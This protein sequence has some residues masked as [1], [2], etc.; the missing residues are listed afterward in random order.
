MAKRTRE[1][2]VPDET[3]E[4]LRTLLIVEL[5]VAGVAQQKIRSIV[6]ADMNKVNKIVRALRRKAKASNKE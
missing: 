6:G 2:N 5:G 1:S 4:L 3:A